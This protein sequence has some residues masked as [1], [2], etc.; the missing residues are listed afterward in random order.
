MMNEKMS[1]MQFTCTAD[2]IWSSGFMGF[3][4]VSAAACGDSGI[5]SLQ[6][7]IEEKYLI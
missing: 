7:L 6:G 5:L 2:C 1:K 3:A 4:F